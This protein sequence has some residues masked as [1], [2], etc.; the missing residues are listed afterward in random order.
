MH[1]KTVGPHTFYEGAPPLL[2]FAGAGSSVTSWAVVGQLVM[3]VTEQ[4][5]LLPQIDDALLCLISN[6]EQKGTFY[7][8]SVDDDD[9]KQRPCIR[10]PLSP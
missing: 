5:G 2:R 9:D 1:Q 4:A 3:T 6:L 10:T 8:N 7:G